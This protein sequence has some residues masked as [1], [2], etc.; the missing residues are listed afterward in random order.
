MVARLI[1]RLM[2]VGNPNIP[3]HGVLR[4]TELLQNIRVF[5][6]AS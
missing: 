4:R 6:K 3:K 5:R 2:T 1:I